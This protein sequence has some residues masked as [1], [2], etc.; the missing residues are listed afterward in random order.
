MEFIS[1]A[2]QQYAE[3]H[4]DIEP[5]YLYQLNRYTHLNVL[6]P[7]MLSGQLQGRFI[8]LISQLIKPE[9][10]LDIGTYTGYSALCIAEG[11]TPNG[12]VHTLDNNE[13]LM[14][15]FNDYLTKTPFQNQVKIHCGDAIDSIQKLNQEI[16]HWDLVWIDADKENYLNYYKNTIDKLRSGGVIMADNVLWSGKIIEE[17]DKKDK[18]TLALKEFNDYVLSDERVNKVLLPIRDGIMM[19]LKK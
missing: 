17:I 6:K 16:P 10:A 7:R 3:K 14:H 2:I 19:I 1:K 5:D 4:S 15:F 11:L 18:D 8:A 13:E 12:T 9:F